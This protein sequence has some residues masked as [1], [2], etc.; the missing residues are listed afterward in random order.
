M[1]K[2]ELHPLLLF[3][4]IVKKLQTCYF[5]YFGSSWLYPS[6]M[7][8]SPCRKLWSPKFWNQL[9]G[10]WALSFNKTKRKIFL[11]NFEIYFERN[12]LIFIKYLLIWTKGKEE[13]SWSISRGA[14]KEIFDFYKNFT[15]LTLYTFT[16]LFSHFFW[17]VIIH[18]S[19]QPFARHPAL[20]PAYPFFEN[21]CFPTLFSIP[22]PFRNTLYIPPTP[23]PDS[24]TTNLIQLANLSL[25]PSHWGYLF[26]ATS[27]SRLNSDETNQANIVVRRV[28]LLGVLYWYK[29]C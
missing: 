21:F 10:N 22:H 12:F 16:F 26:S 25:I 13:F 11:F 1:L 23:T 14:L 27:H 28:G 5:E 3:W 8:L 20:Y 17:L 2:N 9:V 19:S 6:T 4:D 24:Q 18:K 29:Y 7:T 15:C